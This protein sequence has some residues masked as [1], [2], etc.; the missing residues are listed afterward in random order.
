MPA[1]PPGHR[2][3]CNQRVAATLHEA[4]R[5]AHGVQVGEHMSRTR[6]IGVPDKIRESSVELSL[7]A[8]QLRKAAAT[9]NHEMPGSWLYSG[10]RATLRW[11]GGGGGG[12]DSEQYGS[13]D[14]DAVDRLHLFRPPWGPEATT[15]N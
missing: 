8:V 4:R 9:K 15:Y 10:V 2:I 13:A 3:H 7:C 1:D 11:A 5:R 12:D 14:C 6:E